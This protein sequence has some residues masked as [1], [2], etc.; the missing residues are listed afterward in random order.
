MQLWQFTLNLA[1]PNLQGKPNPTAGQSSFRS[2]ASAPSWGSRSNVEN[3]FSTVSSALGLEGSEV[4]RK[5]PQL[6]AVAA[7]AA[8]TLTYGTQE[9]VTVGEVDFEAGLRNN[10]QILGNM[11]KDVEYK[12]LAT[13]RLALFTLAIQN[14]GRDVD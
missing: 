11:G 14:K 8:P 13:N 4:T 1:T 2:A 5:T 12:I 6:R 3:P 9:D 7:Q 10:I